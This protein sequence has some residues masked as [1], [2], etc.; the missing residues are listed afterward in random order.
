[1]ADRTR[2]DRRNKVCSV[3]TAASAWEGWDTTA[4]LIFLHNIPP[5]TRRKYAESMHVRSDWGRINP[6]ILAGELAK[7]AEKDSE[8]TKKEAAE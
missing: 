6:V 3:C 5:E 7:M 8:T 4:E 1:M 2:I